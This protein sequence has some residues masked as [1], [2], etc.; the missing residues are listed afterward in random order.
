M[1][2]V[3]RALVPTGIPE[4]VFLVIVLGIVP[5]S[6]CFYCCDN[7]LVLGSEML[8][9]HLL[10]HTTSNLLLLW[11]IEENGGAIF[12]MKHTSAMDAEGGVVERTGA[13]I[14]AL[15]VEGC[16]VMCAIK[17]LCE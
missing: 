5:G 4:Q 15:G 2:S 7:L 11:C 16:G 8:L 1:K 17:I 14:C 3:R 13:A 6:R 9:L 12:Y 10:R